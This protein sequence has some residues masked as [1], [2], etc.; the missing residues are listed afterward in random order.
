MSPDPFDLTDVARLV[1][2]SLYYGE[3]NE[4]GS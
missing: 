3:K 1:Q 2:H 4:N